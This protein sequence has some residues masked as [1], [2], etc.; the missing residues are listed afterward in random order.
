MFLDDI[1]K[2]HNCKYK[3]KENGWYQFHLSCLH[4]M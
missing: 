3:K 2:K 4:E 1:I